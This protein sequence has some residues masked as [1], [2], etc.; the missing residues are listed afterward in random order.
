MTLNDYILSIKNKRIAV[1]G[2]GVSNTPLIRLLLSY[3]CDVTACDA[4]D[5]AHMGE[6]AFELIRLGA[7]LKLGEKYGVE[8]LSTMSKS[9]SFAQPLAMSE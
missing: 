3:G 2:I 8:K 1:I 5:L 6:E 4:R 9:S 7:K